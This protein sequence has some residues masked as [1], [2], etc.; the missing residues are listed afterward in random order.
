M[1]N[2]ELVIGQTLEECLLPTSPYFQIVF[3]EAWII[4]AS[5][6]PHKR[7]YLF[8]L[9]WIIDIAFPQ[10]DSNLEYLIL[11]DFKNSLLLINRFY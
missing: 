6:S 8:H 11:F 2:N 7:M 1:A 4:I 10:V 5:E 9:G 3:F